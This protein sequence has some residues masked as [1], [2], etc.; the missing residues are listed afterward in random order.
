MKLA[1]EVN[2]LTI[3]TEGVN[4]NIR[5]SFGEEAAN[6][7]V[8]RLNPDADADSL[9]LLAEAVAILQG[10]TPMDLISRSEFRLIP[11]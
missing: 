10:V 9:L 4:G 1:K 2:I 6:Y 11:E 5:L 7:T 8:S 3:L